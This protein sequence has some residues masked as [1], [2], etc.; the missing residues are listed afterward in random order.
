[1]CTHMCTASVNTFSLL[2]AWQFQGSSSS[3]QVCAISTAPAE[4]SWWL[5]ETVSCYGVEEENISTNCIYSDLSGIALDI[6]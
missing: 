2:Q 1:M 5:N 6:Q 3:L 4:P